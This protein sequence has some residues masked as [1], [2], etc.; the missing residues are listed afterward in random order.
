MS[1]IT[2]HAATP[3]LRRRHSR[4]QSVVEFALIVPVF[5]LLLLIAI[6]FGR[7]FFSF[8]QISNAAREG[9]SYAASNPTNTMEIQRHIL[10][11]TNAQS[12]VGAG[13]LSAP[14]V[15]CKDTAG[16]AIACSS[17]DGGSGAGNTVTVRATEHF[18]FFTPLINEFF[19]NN[20]DMSASSTSVVLGYTGSTTA[21]PPGLCSPPTATFTMVVNQTTITTDPS[22]S[23]PNSGACTISGYNWDW[24]DGNTSVGTASSTTHIYLAAQTYT[25]T[26]TTTNQGGAT[27]A[28]ESVTVSTVTPPS[29]AKPVANFTYTQAS[30][31][32]SYTDTSTVADV[33]N[34]PITAWL[35]TFDDGIQSNA[36]NPTYTYGSANAHTATLVV[37]DAGGSSSVGPK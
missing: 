21:I 17:A 34:C 28:T 14:T 36:Q 9:A 19:G 13:T 12:Q 30:K 7:L 16:A 3:A 5:L 37:T 6:D 18:T 10:L 1:F 26:L 4:G 8:I 2:W 24:G 20:F 11:E 15:T 29:C 31:V 33:T 23:R 25:V 27:T 35:W 32:Y 22:A